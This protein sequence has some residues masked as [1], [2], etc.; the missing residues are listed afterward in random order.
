MDIHDFKTFLEVS[1]TRHF[2]QAAANLF[3][4]QST[5]SAR[6][7]LLEDQL[8]TKLFVRQ[9]NNIQLT[10]AGER[11]LSYAE[12]ITTAWNR[13]R[14]DIGVAEPGQQSFVVG[15]MSSLWDITLQ[16][17]L[18]TIYHEQKNL[19]I[20][21][22]VQTATVL[23][24]RILNGTMDLAFLYDVPQNDELVVVRLPDIQLILVSSQPDKSC[25]DSMSEKYILV[26][27][28]P[29]FL[30]QH[31]QAFTDIP[32]PMLH[33]GLGRIALELL[34]SGGGSAYLAEPMIDEY[35]QSGVV[36][37]VQDAPVFHRAAYA[38]YNKNNDKG[39]LVKVLL[40]N[41][42]DGCNP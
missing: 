26:D 1:R 22:E 35:L 21:A 36:H 24:K 32:N 11:M 30:T 16:K 12:L 23:Q 7:R 25:T 31:A 33:I 18:E 10:P 5:V 34:L 4:T 42:G 8:G 17:W 27:W 38:I 20:Y 13:A 29:V 39:D 28:G 15:G 19:V 2:G 9:R 40:G 6:I 41:I 3:I 37:R 14:Q